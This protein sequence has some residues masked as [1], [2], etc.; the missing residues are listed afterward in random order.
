MK[1]LITVLTFMCIFTLGAFAQ[2]NFTLSGSVTD[3][4]GAPVA[5]QLVCIYTDSSQTSF[6]YYNCVNTNSSG[7]YSVVIPGACLPGPN[8]V[9]YVNVNACNNF[10]FQQ[11]QNNQGTTCSG[12]ANFVVCS[13]TSTGC[14]TTMYA[15]PDS[16]VNPYNFFFYGFA[17]QNGLPAT[18]ASYVWDFGDGSPLSSLPGPTHTY[19]AA[20]TYVVCLTTTTTTGCSNTTCTTVTIAG[21][22]GCNAQFG[23]QS[24]GAGNSTYFNAWFGANYYYFWS[25]GDGSSGTGQFPIHTYT[26]AGNYTVCLTVIDSTAGCSD[27]V[28]YAINI[29]GAQPTYY[30]YGQVSLQ[31]L[32]FL[33]AADYGTVYLIR[34]DSLLLNAIDT[35]SIDSGGFYFFSGVPSGTYL[36]KAALDSNSAYYSYYMPTYHSNSLFWTTATQVSVFNS[37]VTANISMIQ[38]VNPGGPG[39]IGGSVLQG[40]NRMASPGDPIVGITILLLDMNNNPVASTKTDASGNYGFSNIAYGTYKVYAEV[41]GKT[42][43]PSIVTINA[44]N[45]TVS[46]VNVEVNSSTILN[47]IKTGA[48]EQEIAVGL[49]PNPANDFVSLTID[50]KESST[51]LVSIENSLGQV[52][53]QTEYKLTLGQNTLVE[54]LTQLAKG[55]YSISVT[56]NSQQSHLKFVKSE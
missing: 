10:L 56:T 25:F 28:C 35:T 22:S 26:S 33:T 29:T 8:I 27:N 14:T 50:M 43:V 21:V 23:Y 16:T 11:V 20:G 49:Y 3:S 39:F 5:N 36:V 46:N 53:K 34:Q 32:G 54:S 4:S 19:A 38:G 37:T 40:A 6:V 2:G 18:V 17:T 7:T 41:A 44:A 24:S 45:P 12:V 42:T 52:V 9:F 51:A 47:I 48:Q 15:I 31:G 1:K 30:V 55:V 13:G